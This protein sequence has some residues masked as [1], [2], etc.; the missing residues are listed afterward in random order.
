VTQSYRL[1]PIF[2]THGN[3]TAGNPLTAATYN[4]YDPGH[5]PHPYRLSLQRARNR[6]TR[7][8]PGLIPRTAAARAVVNPSTATNS[9]TDLSA[10]DNER[11]L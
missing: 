8:V 10:A 5:R 3:Q 6:R 4:G 1:H 11:D 7:A 9:M 2:G